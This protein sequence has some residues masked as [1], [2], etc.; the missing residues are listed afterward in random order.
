MYVHVCIYIFIF[1]WMYI[2]VCVHACVCMCVCVYSCVYVFMCVYAC[3]HCQF[4]FSIGNGNASDWGCLA[5]QYNTMLTVHRRVVDNAMCN[6]HALRTVRMVV[7]D[8]FALPRR[9]TSGLTNAT[10][11]PTHLMSMPMSALADA[12]YSTVP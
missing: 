4:I 2:Y 9:I 5:C 1:L 7:L 11:P 3:A 12:P 10:P 8:E 6:T